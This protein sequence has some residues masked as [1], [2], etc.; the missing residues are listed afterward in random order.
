MPITNYIY[1]LSCISTRTHE[2]ANVLLA[3]SSKH[4]LFYEMI[5]EKKATAENDDIA[6]V[7]LYQFHLNKKVNKKFKQ[8]NLQGA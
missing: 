1:N 5:L 8:Y 6:G 2:K 4:E 7:F 3:A